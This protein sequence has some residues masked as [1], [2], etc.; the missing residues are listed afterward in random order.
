MPSLCNKQET[1]D[2]V[3]S[4]NVSNSKLYHGPNFLSETRVTVFSMSQIFGKKKVVLINELYFLYRS[5]TI[6]EKRKGTTPAKQFVGVVIVY[7]VSL[8]LALPTLLRYGYIA[9]FCFAWC[10]PLVVVTMMV[11]LI[12]MEM[13]KRTS[14]RLAGGDDIEN[15]QR[16]HTATRKSVMVIVLIA[17]QF[18]LLTCPYQLIAFVPPGT[19]IS[20]WFNCLSYV[21]GCIKPIIIAL[22]FKS[23]NEDESRTEEA[24]RTTAPRG[25]EPFTNKTFVGDDLAETSH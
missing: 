1:T 24:S 12:F 14:G 2:Q 9:Y 25:F 3:D 5:I 8:L 22:M 19:Q 16:K 21:N 13:R 15:M 10:V 17:I 7:L 20:F 4:K 11:F 18:F 6:P 23:I